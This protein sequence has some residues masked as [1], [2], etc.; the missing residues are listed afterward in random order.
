[1]KW[2]KNACHPSISSCNCTHTESMK[3]PEE[4]QCAPSP[5]QTYYH[6]I[7]TWHTTLLS[8][9]PQN[10]TSSPTTKQR[11]DSTRLPHNSLLTTDEVQNYYIM[12]AD[13]RRMINVHSTKF[14]HKPAVLVDSYQTFL[15][16]VVSFH[17]LCALAQHGSSSAGS[18]CIPPRTAAD[19]IFC[20][21]A[22][23]PLNWNFQMEAFQI[24]SRSAYHMKACDVTCLGLGLG[25]AWGIQAIPL[26]P[27]EDLSRPTFI[28]RKRLFPTY[29]HS[30]NNATWRRGYKMSQ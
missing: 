16:W 13:G 17:S 28:R 2:Q 21:V 3:A 14:C 7:S 6:D 9:P 25:L 29:N 26:G 18:G 27:A 12:T 30:W 10:K 23:I 1:M 19:W 22:Q 20:S 24:R 5:S 15:G 4:W 11:N 8:L